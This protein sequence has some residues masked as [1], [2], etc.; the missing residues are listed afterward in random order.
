MGLKEKEVHLRVSMEEWQ[1]LGTL[2]NH[3]L[4]IR[5]L[6][7]KDRLERKD[8][9]H[10]DKKILEHKEAMGQLVNHAKSRHFK[11]HSKFAKAM[12]EAVLVV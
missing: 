1:Y 8:P 11:T 3:S 12:E 5:E 6:I 4:Y 10:I 7:D 9:K 2:E